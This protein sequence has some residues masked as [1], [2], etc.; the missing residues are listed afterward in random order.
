M[1]ISCLSS[2]D[3]RMITSSCLRHYDAE[4]EFYFPSALIIEEP[5]VLFGQCN[6]Y[7]KMTTVVI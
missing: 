5:S 3:Q 7:S 6:V 4:T 1:F 2:V